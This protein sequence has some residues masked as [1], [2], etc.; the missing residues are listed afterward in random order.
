MA[1][2]AISSLK[3]R[4]PLLSLLLIALLPSAIALSSCYGLCS[5]SNDCEGQL[6]CTGGRCSDDPDVGA[7]ICSGAGSASK[8]DDNCSPNGS[9]ECKGESYATYTCSPPVFASTE[10]IFTHNDFSEGGDG[11]WPSKC[12]GKYHNN[13]EPVVALSTGWFNDRPLC[14]KMISITYDG[15]STTAKVV[16]ECDSMRGCDDEHAGQPPCRNNIV[17]GSI[18]VWDALGLD[19]DATTDNVYVTW[20]IPE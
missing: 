8:D 15:R 20:S 16:D 11:G 7:H 12:D 10:A 1:T 14:F 18:A 3:P 2:A 17:D 13:S 6:I 4:L 5:A 19:P 9:M